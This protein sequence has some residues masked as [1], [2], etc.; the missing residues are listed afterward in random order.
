MA[1]ELQT[2][3]F[4]KPL[5]L[6]HTLKTRYVFGWQSWQLSF[7]LPWCSYLCLSTRVFKT[8]K[9]EHSVH[10]IAKATEN[11]KDTRVATI[12]KRFDVGVF[13]TP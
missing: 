4:L 2:P 3:R 6:G 8:R 12:L 5:S 1:S 10:I 11:R 13:K 7:S 9:Y